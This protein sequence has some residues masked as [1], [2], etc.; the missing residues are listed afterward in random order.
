MAAIMSPRSHRG[1]MQFGVLRRIPPLALL[2][3][4]L[5]LAG[6]LPVQVVSVGLVGARLPVNLATQAGQPYDASNIEKDVRALWNTGR[7]EDI[8]VSTTQAAGGT[9]VVFHV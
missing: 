1:R 7:L 3:T 5:A 6:D 4:Y 9:A 2:F 8:R